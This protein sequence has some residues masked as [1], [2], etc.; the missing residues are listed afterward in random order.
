L[1]QLDAG[2]AA[3]G[4]KADRN[5]MKRGHQQRA[6]NPGKDYFFEI[7]FHII[8]ILLIIGFVKNGSMFV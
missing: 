7:V 4:D 6:G 2:I 1:D 8:L 3:N 5:R